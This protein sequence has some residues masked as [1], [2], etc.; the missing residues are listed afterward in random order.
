MNSNYL[1]DWNLL[2]KS[3]SREMKTNNLMFKSDYVTRILICGI[4]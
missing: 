4:T 1:D 2:A 3:L